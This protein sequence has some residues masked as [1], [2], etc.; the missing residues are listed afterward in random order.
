MRSYLTAAGDGVRSYKDRHFMYAMH[1]I[2]IARL[3]RIPT[4]EVQ[5]PKQN[6]QY[7][8]SEAGLLRC[9]SLLYSACTYVRCT[10]EA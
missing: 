4:T 8:T 5:I 9:Y 2:R 7:Q 10:A 3:F 1:F 6:D